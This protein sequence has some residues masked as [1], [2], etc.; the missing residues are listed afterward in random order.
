MTNP[1]TGADN[2][3][4]TPPPGQPQQPVGAPAG[5]AMPNQGIPQGA[6][7]V[8]L[9][10]PPQEK[11]G[12][13]GKVI[14][15]VIVALALVGLAAWGAWTLLGGSLEDRVAAAVED[16]REQTD[17]PMTI[18]GYT[19]WTS[20]EADGTS[21]IYNYEVTGLTAAD[22]DAEVAKASTASAAC[23]TEDTKDLLDED[24]TMVYHYSFEGSD[25][26][27]EYAVTK[28]DC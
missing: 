4:T 22:I 10:P 19:T 9:A 25:E 17:L 7:G 20:I 1:P 11:K 23:N 2:Q 5:Q 24:I 27:L 16:A 8:N 14:V 28:A 15:G 26:T 21:I 6:P 12:S 3:P 13:A 18:D